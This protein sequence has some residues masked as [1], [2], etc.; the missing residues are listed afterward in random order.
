MARDASNE[1]AEE[2]RV[3][4]GT[5]CGVLVTRDDGLPSAQP[6]VASQVRHAAHCLT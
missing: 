5:P 1:I 4:T 2:L 6:L 3:E